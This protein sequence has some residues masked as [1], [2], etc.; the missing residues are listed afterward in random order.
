MAIVTT[1]DEVGGGGAAG[2]V[3]S[4]GP[5]L[6]GFC[7]ALGLESTRTHAE[8]DADALRRVLADGDAE[9]VVTTGGVSA[10]DRDLVPRVAAQLGFATVFHHVAM[11]PG[12]PVLLARRGD[13][14]LVGLPGNPV[15]VLA[16]AHL[17]LLPLLQRMMGRGASPWVDLP[18]AVPWQHRGPR[19]LFLPARVVA[20]GIAPMRWNGSGDLIAAAAADGLVDLASGGEWAV[21]AVVRFLPYVGHTIGERGVMPERV[22]RG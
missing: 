6:S 5:Y 22:G 9:V 19:Q 21:G 14:F 16:T 20:G 3:D 17:V 10:G 8:D 7:A 13:R 11:Q 1:G 2:I 4:N 12:K 15:S 18:L